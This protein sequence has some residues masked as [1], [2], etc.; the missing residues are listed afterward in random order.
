MSTNQLDDQRTV[1]DRSAVI[2]PAVLI[3]A[4][5]VVARPYM[6][7]AL[8]ATSASSWAVPAITVLAAGVVVVDEWRDYAPRPLALAIMSVG[9][10]LAVMALGIWTL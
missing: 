6:A 8:G 10:V 7:W 5:A 2:V 4:L 9:G 1:W 3:A